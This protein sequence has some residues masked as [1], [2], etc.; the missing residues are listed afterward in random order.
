MLMVMS[1]FGSVSMKNPDTRSDH[2]PSIEVMIPLITILPKFKD[3]FTNKDYIGPDINE[4]FMN[5][6]A[7][8]E[9]GNRTTIVNHKGYLGKYQFG[10]ATLKTLGIEVSRDSFLNDE[11]L[12]DYAMRMNIR[13]NYMRLK[14]L[15]AQFNGTYKDGVRITTAGILAGAHLTG[16][17]GVLSFF[18]PDEYHYDTTDANGIGVLDYM[19][20]FENYDVRP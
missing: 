11:Q 6:I 5:A 14:N 19:R 4:D 3:G 15:I 13:R 17:G 18:Y 8:T 12:Q 9:S 2:P 20:M 16:P 7:E 10:P 1:I